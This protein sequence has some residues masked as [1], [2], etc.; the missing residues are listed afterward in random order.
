[1]N[2]TDTQQS[3]FKL[4]RGVIPAGEKILILNDHEAGVSMEVLTQRYARS[5]KVLLKLLQDQQQQ[6]ISQARAKTLRMV[7]EVPLEDH[8]IKIPMGLSVPLS[9]PVG[10]DA[11]NT[12][13]FLQ[14]VTALMERLQAPTEPASSIT[15]LEEALHA[16]PPVVTEGSLQDRLAQRREVKK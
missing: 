10:L 8:E 13:V 4:Q 2:A 15:P 9:L 6:P 3:P 1:M 5:E 7:V 11:T 16:S 14:Q 12:T